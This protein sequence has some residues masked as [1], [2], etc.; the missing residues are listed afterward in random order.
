[1][2]YCLIQYTFAVIKM[3]KASNKVTVSG[4]V[5]RDVDK[6]LSLIAKQK[7]TTKSQLIS[8]LLSEIIQKKNEEI[9]DTKYS[10]LEKQ[11]MKTDERLASLLIK[12]GKLDAQSLFLLLRLI[13]LTGLDK[14]SIDKVWGESLSFAGNFLKK[15][16]KNGLQDDKD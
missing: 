12:F 9:E 7:K 14:E 3:R 8:E 1:M 16:L 13:Q 15:P 10:K 4:F 5:S 2:L 11:L 6:S